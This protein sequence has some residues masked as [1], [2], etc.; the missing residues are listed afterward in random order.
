MS[1]SGFKP[2]PK[3]LANAPKEVRENRG[4]SPAMDALEA[5][6]RVLAGM[7]NND[8]YILTTPEFEQEFKDRGEAIVASVPK[9]VKAPPNREAVGRMILG[10]ADVCAGAGSAAVSEGVMRSARHA[11]RNANSAQSVVRV[12]RVAR[13]WG[14]SDFPVL[15]EIPQEK[16][17]IFLAEASKSEMP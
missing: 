5:G 15:P 1:D 11:R 14:R 6:Q 8:L 12:E 7:R 3:M 9:D 17:D 2:D 10:Q 4:P 13:A 16:M